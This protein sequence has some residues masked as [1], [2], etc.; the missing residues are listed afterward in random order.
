MSNQAMLFMIYAIIA[1]AFIAPAILSGTAMRRLTGWTRVL[2][3]PALLIG[4]TAIPYAWLEPQLREASKHGPDAGGF[5]GIAM[6]LLMAITLLSS[7]VGLAVGGVIVYRRQRARTGDI[8][9]V[10]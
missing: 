8:P 2:V 1:T 6:D 10:F 9:A 4:L 5:I 3:V 7:L